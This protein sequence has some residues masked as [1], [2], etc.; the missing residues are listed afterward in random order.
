MT[1]LVALGGAVGA[2]LRFVVDGAVQARTQSPFPWGILLVN[3][4]GSLSL[5]LL[6]GAA[7]RGWLGGE[8]SAFLAIGVCGALTTYSTFALDT[9]ALIRH[10]RRWLAL[11]NVVASVL[12]CLG[13]AWLG[14]A[15]VT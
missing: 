11:A 10:G 15:L 9:H 4:A 14:L 1:L 8:A 7:Q 13:A 12:L 5:G 3:V 2:V 6:V